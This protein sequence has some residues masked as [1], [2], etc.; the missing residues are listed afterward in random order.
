MQSPEDI[1]EQIA[2][3]RKLQEQP[4]HAKPPSG[5]GMAMRVAIELIAAVAVGSM[6]GYWLDQ[7][8]GVAPLFLIICMLFGTVTGL[9]TVKRVNEAFAEKMEAVEREEQALKK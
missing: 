9:V 7:W 4:T 6:I 2:A 5:S 1:A 8:L 3:L